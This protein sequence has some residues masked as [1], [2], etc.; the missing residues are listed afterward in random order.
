MPELAPD[1]STEPSA[2]LRIARACVTPGCGSVFYVATIF[3]TASCP[4]CAG[5]RDSYRLS[6]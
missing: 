4:V 3:T 5:S 2:S 1:A 6:A